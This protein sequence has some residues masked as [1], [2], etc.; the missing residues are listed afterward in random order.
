MVGIVVR[1][2][3]AEKAGFAEDGNDLALL[4]EDRIIG[5]RIGEGESGAVIIL[6]GA[7]HFRG[8]DD[9]DPGARFIAGE[10]RGHEESPALEK[11]VKRNERGG[12]QADETIANIIEKVFVIEMIVL[13]FMNGIIDKHIC[14]FTVIRNNSTVDD[15]IH[16]VNRGGSIG[17]NE[18]DRPVKINLSAG[19][20]LDIRYHGE[21]LL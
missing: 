7:E 2:V 3:K 21:H 15:F 4:A 17:R 5:E 20:D 9:L 14:D 8:G 6:E 1:K 10:E 19:G 18:P 13:L 11:L 16:N 12:V